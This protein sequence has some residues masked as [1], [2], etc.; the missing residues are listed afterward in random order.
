MSALKVPEVVVVTG[1][2]A[3]VGR[4]VVRE[5]ARDR[6]RIG[7]L[8]RGPDGLEAARREVEAA[9]GRALALPTDVA[10]PDAV[11]RAAAAVE[12]ELGPIDVWINNAMVGVF[13]PVKETTAAEFRRVTE[14][15]YLGYVHGTLSAL[16]RMLPRDRGM[17]LQVGSALCYR[18]IPLQAAYCGAKH[19][20]QGFTESLRCELIHDKSNVKVSMV[21]LPAVNTPQHTWARSRMPRQAQP[22]PPIYQPEVVARAIHYAAHH[23]R[24]E[25]DVGLV[26]DVILAGNAV[27]PALGDWYLGRT[28][29]ESQMTD[30]PE[31]PGRPDNLYAPL[32]GDHGA[33]GRPVPD[34]VT[35]SEQWWATKNRGWLLAG[36][37]VAAA[38]WL[39]APT[40]A[41]EGRR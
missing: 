16:R 37:G 38:A 15:T 19:A 27:A 34:A 39:L 18:G 7:L 3:G 13:A 5:F 21:H 33:R 11:E 2:S 20:I 29:Y 23:Y 1:A 8:A 36:L 14:V 17:I 24:R 22:V 25:W 28:G 35:S 6:A 12:R 40:G 31:D 30:V 32:P 10:D 26:T 41:R 9:G 4:A